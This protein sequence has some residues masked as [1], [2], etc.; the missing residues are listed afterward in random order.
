MNTDFIKESLQKNN[1]AFGG[2]TCAGVLYGQDATLRPAFF[3]I[4][5]QLL[6]G[7]IS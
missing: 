4:K 3:P 1:E 6:V 2:K 5:I 7:K